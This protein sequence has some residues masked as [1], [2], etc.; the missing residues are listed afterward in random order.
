VAVAQATSGFA[1]ATRGLVQTTRPQGSPLY[2][3]VYKINFVCPYEVFIHLRT[4]SCGRRRLLKA[5]GFEREPLSS[6][7][8]G[9]F[10]ELLEVCIN[11]L[12]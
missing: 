10:V 6:L 8:V 2:P 5:G 7:I 3:H 12:L 4:L 9:S 1:Q 11:L